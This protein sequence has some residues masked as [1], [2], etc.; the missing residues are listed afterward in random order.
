MPGRMDRYVEIS[1]VM[2]AVF[3]ELQ[4]DRR[5]AFARRGFS[6][7]R[8]EPQ[9]LLGSPIEV[10]RA[11]KRRVRDAT[12]LVVSVGVAPTKMAAKILS[13]MSKPDGLL[14]LGPDDLRD[15][16]RSAAG[17]AAMGRRTGDA[18]ADAS[19]GNPDGRRTGARA[20]RASCMRCFGSDGTASARTRHGT[21]PAPGRRR[22]A[23]QVLRRGEHLRARSRARLARARARADRACRGARPAAARRPRPRAHRDAQA[24]ARAAAR[25]GTLSDADAQP[26]ARR[27]DRRRRRTIANTR[28][29]LLARVRERDR[30]RL[31]GVQV[32]N[33][34]RD[35]QADAAQLALFVRRRRART[36]RGATG[37]IARSTR[38]PRVSAKTRS[39]AASPTPS[40]PRRRAES[41]SRARHAQAG[42]ASS[43]SRNSP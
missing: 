4:P 13:D 41:S 39:R 5:A 1:R 6:R 16:P 27:S 19:G 24:Q 23:A 7:S 38:S 3:D 14:I 37:S 36:P 26:F 35:A 31:A 32:H 11:L 15:V 29:R 28:D 10:A 21:R 30:V 22:L 40:A 17:R 18:R 20:T 25:A 2:R 8:P 12:G 34:A 43:C 9:R 42:H 33:L